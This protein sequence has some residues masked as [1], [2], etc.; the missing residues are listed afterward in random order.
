M[1][2]TFVLAMVMLGK[3]AF[4]PSSCDATRLGMDSEQFPAADG[5]GLA[6]P[7]CRQQR[8]LWSERS[9]ARI[10]RSYGFVCFRLLQPNAGGNGQPAQPLKAAAHSSLLLK[11]AAVS[12]KMVTRSAAKAP[13]GNPATRNFP[14][15]LPWQHCLRQAQLAASTL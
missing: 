2:Q 13:L 1:N 9:L 11:L 12:S 5:S 4:N 10:A 3:Q 14:R 6:L 15:W 7:G 8:H